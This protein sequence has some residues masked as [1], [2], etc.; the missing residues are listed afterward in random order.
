MAYKREFYTEETMLS[1]FFCLPTVKGATLKRNRVAH[2]RSD[3]L[4]KEIG[5]RKAN[6]K[7]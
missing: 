4:Q 2:F 5:V 1:I 6:R 7:S 3:P